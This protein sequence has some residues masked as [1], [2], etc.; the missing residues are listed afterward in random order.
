ME[1]SSGCAFF[2]FTVSAFSPHG[3]LRMDV[4]QPLADIL[5]FEAHTMKLACFVRIILFLKIILALHHTFLFCS[6]HCM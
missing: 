2:Q 3:L 6:S 4:F 1:L 5:S